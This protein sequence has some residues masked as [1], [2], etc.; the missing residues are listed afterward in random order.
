[1]ALDRNRRP[2]ME[3]RSRR[4]GGRVLLIV[5][6][7]VYLVLLAWIVLWRLDVPFV[8]GT[9]R[10]VKLVPFAPSGG[11]GASAPFEVVANFALFLPFGLYLG[12]LAPSWPWW[13]AVSMVTGASVVLEA[14]QYVLAVGISDVT[15]VIVNTAGGLAGIGLLALSRRRFQARTAIVVTWVC[16]TGTVLAVVAVAI[17]VASPLRYGPGSPRDVRTQV[18][19]SN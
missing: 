1:M 17:F 7:L 13:K 4:A 9:L 11:A 14:T 3:Q 10:R 18:S 2:L 8:N 5:L 15:D 19:G 6:F 16:A 12:M